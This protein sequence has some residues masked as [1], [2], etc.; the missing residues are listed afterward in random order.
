MTAPLS[1]QSGGRS[2]R[3]LNRPAEVGAALAA[4]RR[5]LGLTQAEVAERASV[6]RKW[7]SEME[8][9]KATAQVGVLCR[10]LSA[11]E[12]RLEITHMP[13]QR[14]SLRD[15]VLAPLQEPAQCNSTS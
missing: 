11:L 10:V 7:I 1:S 12:A 9:G 6:T 8:N 15:L 14:R 13:S 5:S 2:Y 3:H 4:L